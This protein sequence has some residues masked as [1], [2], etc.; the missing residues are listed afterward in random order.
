MFQPKP[1]CDKT[2]Q[3][4]YT[5]TELAAMFGVA[6]RYQ[7]VVCSSALKLGLRDQ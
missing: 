7:R 4:I 5:Q 3:T 6:D 2:L 1:K